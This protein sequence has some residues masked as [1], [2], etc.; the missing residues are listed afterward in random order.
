MMSE[1]PNQPNSWSGAQDR[2]R[3]HPTPIGRRLLMLLIVL[4]VMGGFTLLIW[5]AAE[6]RKLTGR[7]SVPTPED[8]ERAVVL[9][10]TLAVV[11]SV[12]VAGVA[13]WI[14]HFAWRV[15]KADV[16]PPPGSRHI[17]V[18]RVRRG[19]E[20]QRLA[21]FLSVLAVLL[22]VAGLALVPLVFRLLEQLAP[23]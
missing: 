13:I 15:R 23:P 20:A 7:D 10:R 22:L 9:L 3:P 18:N 11:M 19:P 14:G 16:F 21:R 17:R 5:L 8:I 4:G 12:S 6:V 1:D 2:R